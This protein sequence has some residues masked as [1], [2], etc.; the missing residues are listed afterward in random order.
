M[1]SDPLRVMLIIRYADGRIAK[2]R[3]ASLE[4]AGAANEAHTPGLRDPGASPRNGF[5]MPMGNDTA[6]GLNPAHEPPEAI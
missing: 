5:R 6:N 2:R 3:Y 4:A 1:T